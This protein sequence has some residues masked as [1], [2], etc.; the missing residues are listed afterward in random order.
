[1]SQLAPPLGAPVSPADSFGGPA[2]VAPGSRALRDVIVL[3]RRNLVHVA[4]EP[5]Q[6]SDV[7]IQPV[8]FT[9]LFVY[10]IGGGVSVAGGSY[11]EFAVAGL[12]TLNLTTAA[13][14]TAVGITT[15]LKTGAIDRF[16]ALPIWRAAV[17]V[18]RSLSDLL[19]A[20]L[21]MTMVVLTGLAIGWRPHASVLEF[22]A[23]LAIPLLFAY[24]LS[25]ATACLGLVSDGPESA[26]GIGLVILFP[27]AFVSNAMVPTAGMPA[28]VRAI[29][30][31][32]PVSAVTAATRDLLGNPNPSALSDAWPMQHPVAAA[33]LWSVAIL[34]VAAPLAVRLYRRRTTD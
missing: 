22:V 29:A 3:T 1:M 14:G 26:Q 5:L 12:L 17:L 27:V 6:L 31:W 16:R 32:N 11:K 18:G 21:C 23:A 9:L 30:E 20:A 15:D 33:L 8:L 2:R 28:F 19:A 24:A 34:A 10:V 25:W 13:I 7:L 4:R